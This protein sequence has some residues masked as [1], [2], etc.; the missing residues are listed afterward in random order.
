ME[1]VIT[2]SAQKKLTNILENH[3]GKLSLHYHEDFQG[4]YACS[5]RGVFQLKITENISETVESLD[6]HLGPI[7]VEPENKQ[8]LDEDPSIDF[9][10]DMNTF[11]LKGRSGLLLDNLRVVTD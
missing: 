9:R 10:E 2:P 5:I 4:S 11:Q 8:F 6:T 7:Y 3:S 1:L